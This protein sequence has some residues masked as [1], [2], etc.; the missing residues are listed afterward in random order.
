MGTSV[1]QIDATYG[2]L[3]PDTDEYVRT[4]MDAGDAR[5]MAAERTLTGRSLD[6]HAGPGLQETLSNQGI[7]FRCGREDSNLQGPKPSGT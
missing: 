3:V 1:A 2:H 4:L 6:A 5:R 7:L